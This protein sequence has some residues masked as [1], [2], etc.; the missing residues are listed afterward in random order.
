M[1]EDQGKLQRQYRPVLN[2]DNGARM[3]L[4]HK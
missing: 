1:A 3:L 4:Q 2:F